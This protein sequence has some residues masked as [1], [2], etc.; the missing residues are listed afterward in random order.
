MGDTNDDCIASILKAKNAYE[1]LQ[2]PKTN[3]ERD[4]L[5][6]QYHNLARQVHPD[7]NTSSKSE[8]AFRRLH[9]SYESLL[10]KLST[11]LPVNDEKPQPSVNKKSKESNQKKNSDDAG[12]KTSETRKKKRARPFSEILREWE[13]EDLRFKK[14]NAETWTKY[15]Q[16]K[17]QTKEEYENCEDEPLHID[18][19]SLQNIDRRAQYWRNFSSTMSPN[20]RDDNHESCTE[21]SSSS[22][23][24]SKQNSNKSLNVCWLCRRKFS[25]AE[26]LRQ[27]E[28]MSSLHQLN[29]LL[30]K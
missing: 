7:K 17:M 29:S 13:E 14:E 4:A 20:G 3:L 30:S 2:L 16:R 22:V 23:L 9:E 1:V 8:A 18:E 6:R 10:S 21:E 15:K 19:E 26:L 24:S 27:H 25:S 28:V 11:T 5:R 12:K